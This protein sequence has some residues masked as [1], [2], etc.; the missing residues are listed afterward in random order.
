MDP[1]EVNIPV[2]DAI[3]IGLRLQHTGRIDE[4]ARV[5]RQILEAY[6]DQPDAL[7]FLGMVCYQK[8]KIDESLALIRKAVEVS[9]EYTDAY[10]NLGNVLDQ[11]G[12]HEEAIVAY[13]H[14]IAIDP[15]HLDALNNL[16]VLLKRRGEL[17]EAE[18]TFRRVIRLKPGFADAHYNLGNTLVML[19]RY[20]EAVAAFRRTLAINPKHIEAYKS[21][22]MTLYE[23]G[24]RDAAAEVFSCWLDISADHPIALHMLAVCAGRQVP[25]GASD[26]YITRSFDRFAE[27]FDEHLDAL[28]YRAPDLV[29]EAIRREYGI[30]RSHLSILDAGC[31][32]G[33]CGPLL[34]PFARHLIGVDLSSGMLSKARDKCVYDEL[35]QGELT[36]FLRSHPESYDLIAC[37]DTLV[38]FGDLSRFFRAAAQAL[39]PGGLLAFSIEKAG[40]SAIGTGFEVNMRGRYAHTADYLKETL[41]ESGLSVRSLSLSTLRME[42]GQAVEG[43]VVV[44]KV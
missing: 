12:Q 17:E 9:P 35:V 5:Y 34:Q 21:L 39:L 13:K 11:R 28:D 16:A 33:L 41:K 1:N 29:I 31:G 40:R 4:A 19:D 23:S 38:Y 43:M 42:A 20:R 30:A 25:L 14:V 24:E 8:G 6:P 2:E 7:H 26:G 3:R 22:G 32:T 37:V 44:A 15:E 18:T 27:S 10:N 36:E